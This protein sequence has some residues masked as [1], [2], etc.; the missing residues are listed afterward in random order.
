VSQDCRHD[1]LRR[2]GSAG[3]RIPK[4]LQPALIQHIGLV[5]IIALLVVVGKF[6]IRARI[7]ALFGYP[8][9]TAL[10]VGVGRTQIGELSFVPVRI[11]RSGGLVGEDVYNAT[12]AASVIT[13]LLNAALMR[14][15]PAWIRRGKVRRE[16]GEAAQSAFE[17]PY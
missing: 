10:L 12:L 15:A 9:W 8:F 4:H 13:I 14:S 16:L 5:A 1:R 2:R 3:I 6:V 17:V 7:V 11:A